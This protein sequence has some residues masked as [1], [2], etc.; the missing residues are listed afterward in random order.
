MLFYTL[1]K[2]GLWYIC[3]T[4]ANDNVHVHHVLK[5]APFF[6][7]LGAPA[8][9]TFGMPQNSNGSG[10]LAGP[11]GFG[12]PPPAASMGGQF[13]GFGMQN[14]PTQNFTSGNGTHPFN[15]GN[16]QS[17][18]G[19]AFGFGGGSSTINSGNSSGIFAVGTKGS[20]RP[21]TAQ[22]RARRRR[23]QENC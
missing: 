7:L 11:N 22:A 21:Q 6:F 14:Q 9:S 1:R 17:P 3:F 5:C 12:N 16:M 10:I 8:G 18:P 20:K 2:S 13:T 15:T 4:R 19:A 23:K